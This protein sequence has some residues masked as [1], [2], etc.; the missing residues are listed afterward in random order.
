MNGEECRGRAVSVMRMNLLEKGSS[1]S[2]DS[3]VQL[4]RWAAKSAEY[5][6]RQAIRIKEL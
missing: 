5:A 6:T 2:E 4:A 3:A 1:A